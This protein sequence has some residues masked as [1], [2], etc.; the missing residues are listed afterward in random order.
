VVG[1]GYDVIEVPSRD[2]IGG[3]DVNH[4]KVGQ[5]RG[6]QIFQKSRTY[7]KVLGVTMVTFSKFRADDPQT[8]DAIVTIFVVTANCSPGFVNSWVRYPMIGKERNGIGNRHL[9]ITNLKA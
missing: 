6:T 2:F 9:P 8:L 4:E 5:D 3:T 7:L 1:Q